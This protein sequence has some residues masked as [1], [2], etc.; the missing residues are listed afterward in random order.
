MINICNSGHDEIVFEGRG[1][2]PLC[3]AIAERELL[4]KEI[5][6]LRE[7]QDN[8]KCMQEAKDEDDMD[9]Q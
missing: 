1:S 2:C 5:A 9:G 4:E 7:E 6:E 3:D 8:L